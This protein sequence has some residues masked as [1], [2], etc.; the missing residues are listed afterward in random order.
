VLA[1]KR[2]AQIPRRNKRADGEWLIADGS[3]E[4]L[5]VEM[6]DEELIAFS[7]ELRVPQFTRDERRF[8]SDSRG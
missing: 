5:R 2:G 1:H 3:S 7:S 8:T 6:G 4:V